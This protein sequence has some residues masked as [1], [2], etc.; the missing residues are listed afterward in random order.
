MKLT[1]HTNIGRKQLGSQKRPSSFLL[2]YGWS[3]LSPK[4]TNVDIKDYNVIVLNKFY[5]EALSWI[6]WKVSVY[7][8]CSTWAFWDSFLLNVWHNLRHPVNMSL[9]VMLRSALVIEIVLD[10]RQ[11]SSNTV[12]VARQVK[13]ERERRRMMEYTPSLKQEASTRVYNKINIKSNIENIC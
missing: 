2:W 8:G 6:F 10:W 11:V 4:W 13:V 7:N 9:A 3:Y 12:P 5:N 1:D